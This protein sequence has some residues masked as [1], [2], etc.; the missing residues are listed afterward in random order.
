MTDGVERFKARVVAGG[1]RQQYG[2]DYFKSHAP[3][4]DF[5]IVRVFLNLVLSKEYT[6]AQV[7]VKTAFLNGKLDEDVWIRSPLGI[8]E[9]PPQIF[10]LKRPFMV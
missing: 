9:L 8:P 2:V 1:N 10:K 7:D 6:I 3:V 5:T 4:V